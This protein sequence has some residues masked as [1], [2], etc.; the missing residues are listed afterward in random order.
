MKYVILITG[1][2]SIAIV[3]VLNFYPEETKDFINNHHLY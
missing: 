3:T 2:I 1:I